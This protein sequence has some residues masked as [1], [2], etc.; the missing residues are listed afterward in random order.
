MNKSFRKLK[1]KKWTKNTIEHSNGIIGAEMW[2][3]YIFLGS[4]YVTPVIMVSLMHFPC[5]I[6]EIFAYCDFDLF[7]FL[8]ILLKIHSGYIFKLLVRLALSQTS[9]QRLLFGLLIRC[10]QSAFYYIWL[11]RLEFSCSLNVFYYNLRL[12]IF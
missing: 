8:L 7:V 4:H 6:F 2:P 1:L 9:L 10:S 12:I 5:V 3:Y 11:R